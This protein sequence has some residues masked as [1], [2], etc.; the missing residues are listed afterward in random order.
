MYTSPR[1]SVQVA[2]D[3]NFHADFAHPIEGLVSQYLQS[4]AAI[5][6]MVVGGACDGASRKEVYIYR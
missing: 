2:A 5:E 4:R 6:T 3:H 1:S